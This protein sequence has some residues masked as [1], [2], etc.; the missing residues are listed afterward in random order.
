MS[1]VHCTFEMLAAALEARAASVGGTH[2]IA[3]K[4]EE[5]GESSSG[6][7]PAKRRCTAQVAAP[8]ALS[9]ARSPHPV[10]LG[11]DPAAADLQGEL[12]YASALDAWR[13][14]LTYEAR[15]ALAS[16]QPVPARNVLVLTHAT[17]GQTP[18]GVLTARCESSCERSSLRSGL[19]WGAASLG[20]TSLVG[21]RCSEDAKLQI[22]QA[23]LAL[24]PVLVAARR[25]RPAHAQ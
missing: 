10:A 18:V 20:A 14:A 17:P 2:L 19:L 5:V 8:E 1:D 3:S 6:T 23:E 11:R 4:C 15:M 13:V 9:A 22:C 25:L 7:G 16:T 24:E 12:L 21:T